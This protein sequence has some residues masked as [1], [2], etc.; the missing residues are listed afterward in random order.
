MTNL[1]CNLLTNDNGTTKFIIKQINLFMIS[2]VCVFS[3]KFSIKGESTNRFNLPA[4]NSQKFDI[5]IYIC[6]RMYTFIE[7]KPLEMCTDKT[8]Y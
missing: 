7:N 3:L 8:I 5:Y 6:M 4:L 2:Y 1:S